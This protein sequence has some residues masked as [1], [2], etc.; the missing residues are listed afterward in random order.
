MIKKIL[1]CFGAI[2][3]IAVIVIATAA[4]QSYKFWIQQPTKDAESITIVVNEGASVSSI[5]ADLKDQELISSKFWFKVF[6]K[7]NGSA[8]GLQAGEFELKAG[9]NYQSVIGVLTNAQFA[10]VQIT[11]PE[12][13]TLVQIGELITSNFDISNAE[14]EEVVGIDS[15]LESHEF[16]INAQKP[17][18]V[19]FEGYLFPDTYRFFEDATAEEI[20][21]KLVETMQG[22]IQSST[23]VAPPGWA[24]H[25]LL[26]LA[27]IIEREVRNPDEMAQVADIFLKR[28]EIGMA[29]QADSTVNYITGK[30]TPGISLD[31]R[32]IDS[33]YN[34]YQYPGL[35]P[36]PIS[37]PG[38]NALKAVSIPASNLYFY[39]LTTP[40]GEVIYAETHDQ[41]V[42]NK[43]IYLR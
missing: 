40:E 3:I 42:T 30:K 1:K 14:W 16:I 39:F 34:T 2:V 19:N 15:P 12:G 36:G 4:W 28:L 10:D 38:L 21:T 41:H 22:H 26:T 27:S 24:M 32:D 13:Y 23:I 17:N 6:S 5:A 20:V 37:N 25:D 35:P 8:R 31:D 43:N 9:M 33:P 29:L 7:I 11:I 18:D